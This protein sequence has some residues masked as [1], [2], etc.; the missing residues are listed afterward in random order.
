MQNNYEQA[1]NEIA[2]KMDIGTDVLWA[3]AI[4]QI[5]LIAYVCG[6]LLAI[7]S[8]AYIVFCVKAHMAWH[9][10]SYDR[11]EVIIFTIFVSAVYLVFVTFL[12]Y[13]ILVN[14]YNPEYAA[15]KTLLP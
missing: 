9:D 11:D 5:Y 2:R 6:T 10:G 8:V 1:L 4:K 14:V 12:G 7:L 3:S 15:F 13:E